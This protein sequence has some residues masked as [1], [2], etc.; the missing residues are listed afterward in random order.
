MAKNIEEIIN[1]KTKFKSLMIKNNTKKILFFSMLIGLTPIFYFP[2]KYH[3]ELSIFGFTLTFLFSFTLYMILSIFISLSYIDNLIFFKKYKKN[4]IKND[5]KNLVFN[6]F[7]DVFMDNEEY[8]I[9]NYE[10]IYNYFKENN[11]EEEYVDYLKNTFFKNN[12]IYSNEIP[13]D[14]LKYNKNNIN[15][16]TQVFELEDCKMIRKHLIS[17]IDFWFSIEDT[18]LNELESIQFESLKFDVI[19]KNIESFIKLGKIDNDNGKKLYHYLKK[20]N[21]NSK[22]TNIYEKEMFNK[23]TRS[24]ILLYQ[25]SF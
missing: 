15:I 16:K 8:H 24:D 11:C 4:S 13:K 1:N 10:K 20:N 7:I 9:K 5:N 22:Y 17:I 3:N 6:Y 25:L 18:I 12:F 14:F 23:Q 21:I 19:T 2:F